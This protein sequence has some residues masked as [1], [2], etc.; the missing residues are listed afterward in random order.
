MAEMKLEIITG[1]RVVYSGDAEGV[2]VPGSEGE[3][4][5]LP[6]HA[7]LMTTIKPGEIVVRHG[8]DESFFAVG[9]GFL[10]I[11]DNKVTILA[12]SAERSDEI[13]ETR[14]RE[15]M[16]R[17]EERIAANPVDVDVERAIAALRRSQVRLRVARRRPSSRSTATGQ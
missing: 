8:G 1:E 13:D 6:Y 17:A 10:E 9:G 3:L 2:S 14:V 16:V 15:A 7:A 4:G 5:I 12:D 11:I